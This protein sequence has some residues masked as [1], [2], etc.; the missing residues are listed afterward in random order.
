MAKDKIIYT[1]YFDKGFLLKGLALHS[2]LI[3]HNPN[4]ELWILA[5][6]KY[7]ENILKKMKLKGV[8]V[9]ALKDFEDKELLAVKPARHSV[10]YYWTC[11]PTWVL[12]VIKKSQPKYAVFL[13]ADL[14]FYS[15][16][17]DGVDEIGKKSLLAVEH[18]FPK[19]REGMA[20]TSGRFNVAFNVFKNDKIGVKCLK[21]W[22]KQCL[23]WCY[24]KLED[25]K[26]GD[27]MYLDEWPKLYGKDLVVSKNIGV[28]TAPWNVGQ[29]KISK[30]GKSVLV[31]KTR[32]VCYHFHQFQIIGPS[33]FSRILGYT[34]SRDVIKYIYEPYEDE[35]KR[36]Y[37]KVKEYDKTFKIEA[38]KKDKV[39]LFK[40]KLARSFGPIYWRLK[41]ITQWGK[42]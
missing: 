25:G 11:T 37:K 36:Q 9:V 34:L 39:M 27:Q 38:S 35:L 19:G 15:N 29:Y 8:K 6:D 23:D 26:L 33:H 31:N 5:F 42:D 21:R 17:D 28:D 12:Y 22:R 18:R 16:P 40:Q 1:A 24:W 2:S 4:A 7:T 41:S 20:K 14:F 13:D 3:K 32:L 10:E 30:K